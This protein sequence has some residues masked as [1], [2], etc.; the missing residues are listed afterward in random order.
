MATNLFVNYYRDGASTRQAELDAV[1]RRNIDN[2]HIDR[3]IVLEA[4]PPLTC[5][6]LEA[7]A[8]PRRPTFRLYFEAVNAYSSAADLNIVANSDIYFDD[9]LG[10][11][12]G[13][14]LADRCLALTRW[15]VQADG[16]S[17]HL[18]WSNSQ[19]AWIF[20]GHVKAIS[21]CDFCPGQPACDWR[22]AAELRRC[23]YEVFNPSRDIRSHHLHLSGIRHYSNAEFVHGEHADVPICGVRDIP[24]GR[25]VTGVISFSLFGGDRRY[26]AGAEENVLLA[27]H[28]YPGWVSRFYVDDTVPGA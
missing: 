9:S 21:A 18:G 7:V 5:P 10:L 14:D 16:N 26:T 28:V 1:L 27:R 12:A 20:R 25:P 24:P 2:S 23:G 8:G 13:L 4:T 3:V 15:E 17:R 11:L 22:L 19:D 6:K